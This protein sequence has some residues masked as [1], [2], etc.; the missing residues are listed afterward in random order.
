MRMFTTTRTTLG[1][2]AAVAVMAAGAYLFSGR[3]AAAR[4]NPLSAAAPGAQCCKDDPA[5]QLR[6]TLDPR[7]FQG[8]VRRAY[9]VA[10]DD[11][12]LIAQLHC[13]CGCDKEIGHKNLLDCFRSKHGS[14]CAICVGEALE[15]EQLAKQGMPVEQIRDALRARFAGSHGS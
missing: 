1:T 4:Q 7:L 12:A 14:T 8:D 9:T 6:L 10:Q 11:P 3:G 2:I 15:A 13:Y 5:A